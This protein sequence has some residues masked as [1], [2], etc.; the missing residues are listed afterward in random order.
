MGDPRK[1]MTYRGTNIKSVLAFGNPLLDVTLLSQDK[2][3]EILEKYNLKK[4]SQ[5]EITKDEMVQLSQ[6]IEGE[7]LCISAGGCCQN[8]LRMMQWI[9][10]KKGSAAI[11]GSVGIDPEADILKNTLANDGVITRYIEQTDLP[12]GK[13][14]ALVDGCYRCLVAHIGAAEVLPLQSLLSCENFPSVFA[15]SD[16]ILIETF[17]LT[18]RFETVKYII[19][20]C[21]KN[22][23]Q[24]VCN[25]GGEYIFEVAPEEIKFLIK[26]SHIIIGNLNEFV[27][28][29]NLLSHQ[30]VEQMAENLIKNENVAVK[31][32][33][34]TNGPE[35]TKCFHDGQIEII[36]PPVL[37]EEEILDTT[38]AG[39]AFIG[40]FLAGLSCTKSVPECIQIGFYSASHII[41][42][43][44]CSIP[45]Y[46]STILTEL[47]S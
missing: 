11:F 22:G 20:L 33:V 1:S 34:I 6:D 37:S 7:A 18:N 3:K 14:I 5:R 12:T 40:G 15:S 4:D 27:A 47:F 44:G 9:L 42:Q 10:H 39:D 29:K 45:E 30:S 21:L 16:I 36:R 28:L 8:T 32:I 38:G 43:R 24:L 26:H 31:I 2:I 25:L 13:T 17:F 46:K 19:E 23:K 35:P 41:K